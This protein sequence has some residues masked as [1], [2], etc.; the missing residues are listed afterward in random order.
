MGIVSLN[1]V[2]VYIISLSEYIFSYL[3]ICRVVL[4]VLFCK[5]YYY[6]HIYRNDGKVCHSNVERARGLKLSPCTIVTAI[7]VSRRKNSK[8]RFLRLIFGF[9]L[10]IYK[11]FWCKKIHVWWDWIFGLVS[12]LCTFFSFSVS[13]RYFTLHFIR[14]FFLL[15]SFTVLSFLE[16]I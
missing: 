6:L 16:I 14:I 8:F 10:V 4:R 13:L 15:L 7:G 11:N 5:F 9:P 2:W 1:L 3:I 12:L